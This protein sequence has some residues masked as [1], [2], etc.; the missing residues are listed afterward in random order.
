MVSLALGIENAKRRKSWGVGCVE[1]GV[2]GV[3]TNIIIVGE[4]V[5]ESREYLE[6]LLIL[7]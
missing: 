6:S 5:V 1:Q 3:S 2:P 7:F 4:W